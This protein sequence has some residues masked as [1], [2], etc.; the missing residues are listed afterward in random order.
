MPCCSVTGMPVGRQVVD[1]GSGITV[2]M[3]RTKEGR[4]GKKLKESKTTVAER[5][6]QNLRQGPSATKAP[7]STVLR[8]ARQTWR[9]AGHGV[10][11]TLVEFRHPVHVRLVGEDHLLLQLLFDHVGREGRH[12]A[13][14]A[15]P[16]HV[17]K[18]A[19]GPDGAALVNRQLPQ[20][21][22][23]VIIFDDR[24][25]GRLDPSGE[26]THRQTTRAAKPSVRHRSRLH[27]RQTRKNT[28]L[29]PTSRFVSNVLN[30]RHRPRRS[31]THFARTPRRQNQEEDGAAALVR[32]RKKKGDHSM[33]DLLRSPPDPNPTKE[34]HATLM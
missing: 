28:C 15:L 16:R 4:A 3:R 29:L 9:G 25:N 2:T 7:H 30:S 18:V 6:S 31:T 27:I 1:T 23:T 33:D 24:R 17:P 32:L 11:K 26:P 8:P 13:S 34:P 22:T 19:F 12:A 5:A 10:K 20:V 21:P 14:L